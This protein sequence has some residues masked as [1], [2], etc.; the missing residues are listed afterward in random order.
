MTPE[1]ARRLAV[2]EAQVS[3]INANLGEMS[4]D[5]KSILAM[6]NRW[7]GGIAVMLAFGA[8]LGWFADKIFAFFGK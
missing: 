1:E 5:I 2:V 3:Q 7:R 6:A 4:D 8:I